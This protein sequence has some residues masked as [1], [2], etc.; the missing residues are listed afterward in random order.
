MDWRL[1]DGQSPEAIAGY[2][3][4]RQRRLP[5]I[6]KDSIYRFI[7]S[8]AGRRIETF[9]FLKK[10]RRRHKRTRTGSLAGRTFIDQRPCVI[11]VRRSI[12]DA[13][14]DFIVSG[15][16][17]QGILLVVVDRKS[18][19]AFLELILAVSIAAVHA[20][21]Q[22]IQARFPELQ[23][24]TCDNDLL[25]ARHQELAILLGVTIYFCHPYHSWEKGTVENT[26]GVIRRD[27]PKGSSLSR[28]SPK[29]IMSIE[30][31]LNRRPM[32]CLRYATPQEILEGHR[33]RIRNK[34]RRSNAGW[35]CPSD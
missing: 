28:Y 10:R 11:N 21:F 16:G 14:A 22:R 15:R 27:V 5:A 29:F 9:L 35:S 33:K 24:I 12:G 18:R 1:R 30:Q 8:P 23:T 26:N 31:K 6:S 17:G 25:F 13:E 19:A 4:Q 34:K 20:A 32:K 7:Q 3:S 2:M